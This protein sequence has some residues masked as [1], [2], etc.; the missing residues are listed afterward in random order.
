M[1]NDSGFCFLASK[2]SDADS[3]DDEPLAKIV[4]TESPSVITT[5]LFV[6]LVDFKLWGK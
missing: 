1:L 5:C 3:D 6:V 2:K 4:K